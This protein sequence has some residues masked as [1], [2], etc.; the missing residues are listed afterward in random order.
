MRDSLER[1]GKRP[2][3]MGLVSLRQSVTP[4]DRNARRSR[5]APRNALAA[6]ILA[7]AAARPALAQTYTENILTSFNYYDGYEP[8]ADL[9]L[10]NGTFYSTTNSGGANGFGEVFSVPVTGGTPNVMYSFTGGSDGEHPGAGLTLSTDGTTFYTVGGGVASGSPGGAVLSIPVTGG[11]PSI[12]YSFTSTGTATFGNR[13]GSGDLVLS[14]NTLY[15]TTL[16]GGPSNAGVVFSEPASGGTPT[17][18]Y[19]F[20]G[21]G[22]GRAQPGPGVI[23]SGNTLYGVAERGG[24]SNDGFIYSLPTSGG[25][26]TTLFSFNGTTGN[27]GLIPAAGLTLS[28][29]GSTLY[30]GTALGGSTNEGVVFS[31][32]TSGG[33]PTTLISF[34][35]TGGSAPGYGVYDKLLLIGSTL[36]GTT[37]DGGA[38]NDG[39]VFSVPTTGGTPTVLYSFTGTGADGANPS[40]GLTTDHIVTWNTNSGTWDSATSNWSGNLYG[41]TLVDGI[42]GYGTVFEVSGAMPYMDGDQ[43]TFGGSLS[44]N[45]TVTIQSAGV[46]PAGVTINNTSGFTYTFT[47][48]AITGTGT[49]AVTAGTVVLASSNT[50]S[51]GTAVN[52]GT[53]IVA[54]QNAIPAN[55]ALAIASGAAVATNA[56]SPNFGNIA[57]PDITLSSLSVAG[58]LNLNQSPMVVNYTTTSPLASIAASIASG[59][60]TSSTVLA[61]PSVYGL[62]TKDTGSAVEVMPTLLGDT[63]L[64][65]TVGIGDY[66]AVLTNFGSGT[67]WSQG[68]FHYSGVVGIGDYDDVLSN[69]GAHVGGDLAV[70]PALARSISPAATLNP[71]QAKTDLKLE[72][73]TTT[74]DVYVLATASAAFT[75]YTIS[76]PTAHLLGGSTSPDPD[77]LLS[78][79]AGSGGNT[80][81]YETSGTYADWFKITETA[82][83]VAEGQQQN[84]FG[85][86]SSRDDTINIPAGGTIDFG[87]IYNTA[88]AQQDLTFDFAEA[89]TEPT[90]GP[91]YYGAEVDY[92]SAP[93]PASVSLLVIG[94][95]GLLARRRRKCVVSHE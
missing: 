92:V 20:T 26:P 18:L 3:M 74:G 28:P 49:L 41:T 86:H 8:E 59:N 45:S 15:G 30:G 50:Y 22:N 70:G 42:N 63:Q 80:N 5:H 94:S 66:D 89:G 1:A 23:L 13:V 68:D 90:N 16:L 95:V 62:G 19:S 67:T 76:D 40:G 31:E 21:T 84:G 81:V 2:A 46:A 52:G 85:T 61:S 35:G 38:N 43:A 32:P 88:A 29:D 34:T 51:G 33:A 60:I 53:L 69:Y 54:T 55:T 24:S 4:N 37:E 71:D 48:G 77:K 10:L 64:R 9:T 73:N 91:T 58:T 39:E 78:V 93:E 75:G 44:A 82:S 87:E 83:Q 25:T 79:A 6:I 14:G 11:S 47:G 17:V 65:G 56:T 27:L 7:G 12:L 72:V 57:S 36:Y